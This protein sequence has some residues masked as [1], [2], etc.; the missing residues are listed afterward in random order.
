MKSISIF[1]YRVNK[2]YLKMA[3]NNSTI[4]KSIKKNIFEVHFGH[5]IDCEIFLS[6]KFLG[7]ILELEVPESKEEQRDEVFT[8][9]F[10]RSS[11]YCSSCKFLLISWKF[12]FNN[13]FDLILWAYAEL[14]VAL[15]HLHPARRN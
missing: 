6:I 10:L 5:K 9:H 11:L 1:R 2:L 14:G 13:E 8:I 3:K 4:I 7:V 15:G 12:L